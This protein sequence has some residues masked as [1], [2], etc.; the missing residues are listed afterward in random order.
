MKKIK[1]K[2]Q[3]E[4]PLTLEVL[5]DYNQKVLFPF[6]KE[7]FATKKELYELRNDMTT[8]FDKV[9]QQLKILMTEK[10]MRIY[11]RNKD[12]KLWLYIIK[13]LKEKNIL[14]AKHLEKI[15]E[16]GIF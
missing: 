13:V 9:F 11:Q 5:V 3:S 14:T 12:K 7:T 2:T 4:K 16:M 15:A 10:E 1:T 6:M 8:N